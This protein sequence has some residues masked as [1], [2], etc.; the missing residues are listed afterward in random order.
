MAKKKKTTSTV[1][2]T[3]APVNIIG[4]VNVKKLDKNGKVKETINV[5][6]TAT[7]NLLQGLCYHLLGNIELGR[8]T[9]PKYLGLGYI[10]STAVAT[11]PIMTSLFNELNI[12]RFNL[13]SS[14]IN[15]NMDMFSSS[16]LFTTLITSDSLVN[17]R[18]G[19]N[20]L[21]LFSTFDTDSL[22]ARVYWDPNDSIKLD[23]GESV[24]IT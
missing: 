3:H 5:K 15:L 11:T 24:I 16:V 6:N 22:L 23:V 1:T 14:T 13:S 18:D 10:P 9:Y 7:F 12:S 17:Y 2:I 21:G 8:N 4:N 20:E 19:F